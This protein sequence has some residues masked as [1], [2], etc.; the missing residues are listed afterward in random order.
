L[1]WDGGILAV[2]GGNF[3]G[4][5]GW[6]RV[7]DATRG[8]PLA[9]PE[10]APGQ[11]AALA[12]SPDGRTLA[13]APSSRHFGPPAPPAVGILLYE[14]ATGKLRGRLKDLPTRVAAL[15]FSP[16]GR[17]LACGG[18]DGGI[19]LWDVSTGKQ[20]PRL[21]GHWGAV[22]ALRFSPD[23]ALLAS[24]SADTTG[25]VWDRRG[26]TGKARPVVKL[27][28]EQLGALWD[29]LKGKDA[30]A[31]YR[32]VWKFAA[33]GQRAVSFLGERLRPAPRGDAKRIARLIAD[34]DNKRFAV[35]QGAT[36]ALE[37]L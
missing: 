16:D 12:L 32:A 11:A 3:E 27:S 33:G 36:T 22:E 2:R 37:K 7:W 29:D 25:L 15:A 6:V 10:A 21:P 8:K 13:V 18:Q 30:A 20:L 1:S 5:S 26:L 35:R 23:G 31:A 34:L 28:P 19:R 9:Q 14:V 17:I 24:G 4:G